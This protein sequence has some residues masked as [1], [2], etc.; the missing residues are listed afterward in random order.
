[1]TPQFLLKKSLVDKSQVPPPLPRR[2][3]TQGRVERQR[4]FETYHPL[5]TSPVKGE[6]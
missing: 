2:E 6:G 3:G 4:A 1:M 5:R